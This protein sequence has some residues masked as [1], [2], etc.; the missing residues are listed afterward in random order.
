LD[1]E[2]SNRVAGVP[3]RFEPASMRGELTEAEHL[4]RYSW[5]A[6]LADG[7]RV[8]DAGCGLGYGSK[9]LLRAGAA[10]VVGVDIA[11]PVVEAASA[12]EEPG[13]TF[14]SA[15]VAA[16]H[17]EDGRFDLIVCL[18]VIEHVHEPQRVIGELARLLAP[19]GILVV[20][21]PNRDA[22]VP[23]NP[24]HVHEYLPEELRAALSEALEHVS[25]WRQQGWIC[26]AVLDDE[27]LARDDG[28]PVPDLW[29]EK[30]A[31]ETPGSETYTLALASNAPLP[32]PAPGAVITGTVEVRKW[33][34][35]YDEQAEILR[36]H[37]EHHGRLAAQNGELHEL[38][39]R[40]AEAETALA[41]I[42]GLEQE[43]DEARERL[44]AL[45]RDLPALAARAEAGER[46]LRNVMSSPSW[47]LTAPLRAAKRAVKRLSGAG[48]RTG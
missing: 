13:L 6:R 40:L 47:R 3:E 24:H 15:D 28:A 46:N 42:P 16:L 39:E 43:R 27:T 14:Q 11:E 9:M 38:R 34:D 29:V 5:A 2:L 20:S 23:G 25:L 30:V 4:V 21:S 35:L 1:S 45:E 36:A 10:E 37:H 17:F 44:A 31:A 12:A 22:Y 7:R 33:L 8:L 26:S 41:R 48:R 19:G 18:E 32:E